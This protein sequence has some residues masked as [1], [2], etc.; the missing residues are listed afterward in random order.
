MSFDKNTLVVVKPQLFN[1]FAKQ[2]EGPNY[3]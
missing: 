1:S 3:K 2:V